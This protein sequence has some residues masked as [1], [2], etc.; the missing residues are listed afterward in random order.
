MGRV[1][2]G[3]APNLNITA[4]LPVPVPEPELRET[5]IMRARIMLRGL[6]TD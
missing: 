5:M 3:K 1:W 2:N 6:L 4:I